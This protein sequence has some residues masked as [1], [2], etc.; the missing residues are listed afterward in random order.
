[1]VFGHAILNQNSESLNSYSFEIRVVSKLVNANETAK[2][3]T[4]VHWNLNSET[5]ELVSQGKQSSL[6]SLIVYH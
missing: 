5:S 1:M 6:C 4:R 3:G 2:G